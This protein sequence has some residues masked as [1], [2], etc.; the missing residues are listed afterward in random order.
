MLARQPTNTSQPATAQKRNTENSATEELLAHPKI[1]TPSISTRFDLKTFRLIIAVCSLTLPFAPTALSAQTQPTDAGL[2][3]NP[4]FQNNCAKCH[5]KTGAG[6][7]FA[8][9]SLISEKT[10]A[11]SPDDLRNMISNGKGRM[12]KF[13]TK[14]T[15]E[16]IDTLVHQIQAQNKK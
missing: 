10:A 13:A 11:T 1:F 16:E 9:P 4:V 12:P 3:A 2:A 6:R 8:G 15:P 5:G 7:H 14:L